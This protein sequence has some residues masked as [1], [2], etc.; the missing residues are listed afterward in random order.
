[1][2]FVPISI[3]VM[4]VKSNNFTCTYINHIPSV[5]VLHHFHIISPP[6]RTHQTRI[7]PYHDISHLYHITSLWYHITVTLSI[8]G[9]LTYTPDTQHYQRVNPIPRYM[10]FIS[11]NT[12]SRS[13]HTYI[14]TYHTRI[15][16]YR[17]HITSPRFDVISHLYR[18]SSVTSH[19]YHTH[20]TSKHFH[21][22]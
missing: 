8:L 11:H 5:R 22:T 20:I 15:K 9:L 6:H 2:Q 16:T 3:S 4:Q 14:T 19:L 12:I 13:Y 10:T 17:T 21:N 7:T 1:M 18:T